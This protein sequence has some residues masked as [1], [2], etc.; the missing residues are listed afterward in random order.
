MVREGRGKTKEP[1]VSAPKEFA[2]TEEVVCSA[3]C[4]PTSSISSQPKHLGTGGR[5]AR[6]AH[7][8]PPES[9]I[10]GCLLLERPWSRRGV[11]TGRSLGFFR[12]PVL[13]SQPP[14]WVTLRRPLSLP[15]SVSLWVLGGRCVPRQGAGKGRQR[16]GPGGS[17]TAHCGG[18]GPPGPAEAARGAPPPGRGSRRRQLAAPQ[19]QPQHLPRPDGAGAGAAEPCAPPPAAAAAR[20]AEPQP[21]PSPAAARAL[22]AS[23]PAAGRGRPSPRAPGPRSRGRRLLRR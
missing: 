16:Q 2:E 6:R 9:L 11:L 17:G 15:A 5:R 12:V 20:E 23:E 3:R 19:L 4:G 22:P 8:R 14:I 10:A 7:L 13:A 1:H 21:S 18:P